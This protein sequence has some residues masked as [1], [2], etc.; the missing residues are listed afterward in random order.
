MRID[1]RQIWL[2]SQGF[3]RGICSYSSCPSLGV[4]RT[5]H[6]PSVKVAVGA[7]GILKEQLIMAFVCCAIS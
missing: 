1:P 2:D 3:R 6:V 5:V 7:D 4:D